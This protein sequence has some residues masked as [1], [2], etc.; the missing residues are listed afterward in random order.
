MNALT[1]AV[2][3]TGLF[4]GAEVGVIELMWAAVDVGLLAI[5][6]VPPEPVL[7]EPVSKPQATMPTLSN[8]LIRTSGKERLRDTICCVLL[9]HR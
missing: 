4:I 1:E 6:E 8:R 5:I 2:G 9:L 7:P 3:V